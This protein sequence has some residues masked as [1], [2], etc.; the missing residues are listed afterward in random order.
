MSIVS[1]FENI[2]TF[3]WKMYGYT[4]RIY[5]FEHCVTL[6][7]SM[8]WDYLG[9]NLTHCIESI[10]NYKCMSFFAKN[11]YIINEF[12]SLHPFVLKQNPTYI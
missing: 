7:Y 10:F 8:E 12:N 5:H 9:I 2:E 4:I 1:I 3:Y 6:A 11:F